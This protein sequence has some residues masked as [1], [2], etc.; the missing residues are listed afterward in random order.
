MTLIL[1]YWLDSPIDRGRRDDDDAD[2]FRDKGYRDE[3]DYLDRDKIRERVR[4][5]EEARERRMRE[6]EENSAQRTGVFGGYPNLAR[7]TYATPPYTSDPQNPPMIWLG[8]SLYGTA[9][10][11]VSADVLA[12]IEHVH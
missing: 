12:D 6:Y 1:L 7:G 11:S 2:A 4:A 8:G 5:Y 3:Y 10:S 9:R